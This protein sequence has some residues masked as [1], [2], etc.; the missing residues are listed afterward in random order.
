MTADSSAVSDALWSEVREH[1]DE[2]EAL[3]LAVAAPGGAVRVRGQQNR[4]PLAPV[5]LRHQI[6][7]A[8]AG[9]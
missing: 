8:V 9:V 5:N 2:S 7:D 3:E 1:F 4:L 6:E